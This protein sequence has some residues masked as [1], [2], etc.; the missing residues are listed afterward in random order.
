MFHC[1]YI[2]HFLIDSFTNGC[3]GWFFMVA[4]VNNIAINAGVQIPLYE[5]AFSLLDTYPE[6]ELLHYM[7][8]PSLFV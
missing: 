5:P 3:L 1:I 4:M 2:L 7:V 6:V 8:I